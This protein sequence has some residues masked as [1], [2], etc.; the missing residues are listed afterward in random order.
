MDSEEEED[1][2]DANADQG[3]DPTD[4]AVAS[5]DCVKNWKAAAADEK[6]HTWSIFD[7]T[8]IYASACRHGLILWLC[9]MV[10]SGEL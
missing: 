2:D 9:D 6:K 1:V 5:S 3:G 10:R 8:G 4:G 7:E